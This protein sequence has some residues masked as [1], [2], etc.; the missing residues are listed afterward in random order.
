MHRFPSTTVRESRK[1]FPTGT[2]GTNAGGRESELAMSLI[3]TRRQW[4]KVLGGGAAGF[5]LS[6]LAS[7]QEAPVATEKAPLEERSIELLNTHTL[8]HANVVFKR[9]REYDA[10]ALETLK[11]LLRD[12]RNGEMHDIDPRLYDQ[13]FELALAAN[14]HPHYEVISGY[15]S[16]ESN[17]RM[18]AKPGSGVAKKSLHMQGRAM[19]VRLKNCDCAR[20]RDLALTA[21]QGGVGYYERSDFVHI[22][23]GNFRTWTG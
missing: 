16:P 2:P 6:R 19:D 1:G 12:H 20:L 15:R 7:A 23:T 9:G 22:D 8:E 17:D 21:K 13:L 14:C 4:L 3:W 18:S 5:T 11:K 10:A